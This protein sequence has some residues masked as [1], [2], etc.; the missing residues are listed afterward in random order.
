MRENDPSRKQ[1][2]YFEE[3]NDCTFFYC[4]G[5]TNLEFLRLNESRDSQKFQRFHNRWIEQVSLPATEQ[6]ALLHDNAWSHTTRITQGKAFGT[7]WLCSISSRTN[8][9]F[10]RF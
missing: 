3:I 7:R 10:D 8:H 1:Q 9:L 6:N 5:I 4:R 2:S